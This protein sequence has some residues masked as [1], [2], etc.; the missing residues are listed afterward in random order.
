MLFRIASSGRV[1][2]L[3]AAILLAAAAWSDCHA[4]FGEDLEKPRPEFT[5]QDD[6]IV[7]RLIPRAK[8]TSV[9]FEFRVAGGGL[10]EVQGIDFMTAGTPE[11]DVKEF[12]SSL[13][14]VVITL[15][16]PGTDAEVVI[17]SSFF[18][19][20]T[21][22]WIYH[23]LQT[24]KWKNSLVKPE[25]IS[26]DG[27]YQFRMRVADGS[28]WDGD[29]AV[30][31]V[32]HFMG[33]PRDPFWSY[34][35]GTLVVRFFGVF[36]VLSVLMI[37][38]LSA[39]KLFVWVEGKHRPKA[40]SVSSQTA[41][42]HVEPKPAPRIA[43]KPD[44]KVGPG[45]LMDPVPDPDTVAAIGTALHL[46]GWPNGSMDNDTAAAIAV[47]IHLYRNAGGVESVS[48][49]RQPIKASWTLYGREQIQNVRYQVF[50]RPVS[51]R[52]RS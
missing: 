33:G 22:Y 41:V 50:Q 17:T 26:D 4:M 28:V 37:G 40:A 51:G 13:F 16:T 32:I 6:S 49:F 42:K 39:G 14:D 34:A 45:L 3:I 7:A 20:S 31:G 36:L 27:T 38:M 35:L 10:K 24:D 2:R 23:P 21:E 15:E 18:N 19:L 9:Q 48:S 29:G 1:I 5:R 47:A 30:D 46:V 52:P 44:S 8:S 25:K 12:K 11:V 43:S